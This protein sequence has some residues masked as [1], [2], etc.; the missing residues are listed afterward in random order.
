MQ[1]SSLQHTKH[2]DGDGDDDVA[3]DDV[4]ADDDVVVLHLAADLLELQR[5]VIVK[6]L[7]A[8]QAKLTKGFL[9]DYQELPNLNIHFAYIYCI[10]VYINIFCIYLKLL[11]VLDFPGIAKFS[12][13]LQSLHNI[14]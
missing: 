4:A 1:S 7:K 3:D 11:C 13:G 12:C 8:I 5:I 10:Y 9:I 6:S 14:F 2:N